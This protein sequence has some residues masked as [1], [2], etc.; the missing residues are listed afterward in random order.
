MSKLGNRKASFVFV[1]FLLSLLITL[2]ISLLSYASEDE[3]RLSQLVSKTDFKMNTYNFEGIQIE[4]YYNLKEAVDSA[5]AEIHINSLRT[6]FSEEGLD[7]D[8]EINT[9]DKRKRYIFV[10]FCIVDESE[11][12][13]KDAKAFFSDLELTL[14]ISEEPVYKHNV[15]ISR[16]GLMFINHDFNNAK[17]EPEIGPFLQVFLSQELPNHKSS[18]AKIV[19]GLLL[20]SLARE[21]AFTKD[22]SDAYDSP[23]GSFG[24]ISLSAFDYCLNN[25]YID[26]GWCRDS[27]FYYVMGQQEG[28]AAAE[29][30]SVRVQCIDAGG[31]FCMGTPKYFN[32]VV[33]DC[34]DACS[35]EQNG[36]CHPSCVKGLDCNDVNKEKFLEKTSNGAGCVYADGSSCLSY[37]QPGT[38]QQGRC[39]VDETG[40]EEDNDIDYE[41]DEEESA[42]DISGDDKDEKLERVKI[43]LDYAKSNTIL[44]RR[45]ECEDDCDDFASLIVLYSNRFYEATGEYLDPVIF[46]S[47]LMQ[48]SNCRKRARSGSSAGVAQVNLEVWCGQLGLPADLEECEKVLSSDVGTAI[49]ISAGIL[50][51]KYKESGGERVFEKAKEGDITS[52]FRESDTLYYGVNASIRGYVGWGCPSCPP[53]F[54]EQQC[55]NYKKGHDDYVETVNKRFALLDKYVKEKLKDSESMV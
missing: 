21:V 15:L 26:D 19:N 33:L 13:A 23:C 47:L 3:T 39:I 17:E 5:I 31:F 44:N 7:I 10:Y 37:G 49:D 18:S 52:C 54:T 48:E 32:T 51:T 16:E 46:L 20:S 42:N 4:Q 1:F 14:G 43:A 55:L 34:V 9:N 2:F 8:Y 45:C 30:A 29:Q 35:L 27:A 22:S 40:E 24:S 6:K 36:Q 28:V 25:G 12:C 41:T 53:D 38:C 11:D 50:I